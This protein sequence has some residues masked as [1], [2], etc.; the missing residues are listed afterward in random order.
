MCL[1]VLPHPVSRWSKQPVSGTVCKYFPSLS[2]C[3]RV[4]MNEDEELLGASRHQEPVG[5]QAGL[6]SWPC[7]VEGTA[8]GAQLAA[9]C[10]DMASCLDTASLTQ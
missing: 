6:Q 5:A 9:S 10:P 1:T 8:F 3:C 7:V 4:D 2:W